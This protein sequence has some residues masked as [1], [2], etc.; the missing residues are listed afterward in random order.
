VLDWEHFPAVKRAHVVPR[1]Y[2]QAFAVDGQV[3]VHVDGNERCVLMPISEAGTRSRYYRRVRR[4]G[5]SIDDVE[6]SLSVV[7]DKAARPLAELI[8]GDLV[9]VERKR[10]LTQFIALQMLRGPAFFERREEILKP[11]LDNLE[12][13]DFKSAALAT[14]GGNVEAARRQVVKAYLDPTQRFVTMLATA[15]KVAN[16]LAHMRWNVLRFESSLLA[17][18]D[19]PVVVWP[20]TLDRT[21]PFPKQGF[22]PLSAFEIRLPLAPDV[23]L[24]MNWV[25][26]SDQVDVALRPR[27][28]A[29][30]NAFTIAQADRQWMHQPRSP[31]DVPTGPFLPL[32]RLV[33]PDYDQSVM[34]SSARRGRAAEFLN[35]VRRRRFVDDIEIIIDVAP[36]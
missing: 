28:A 11:L 13:K 10:A 4:G 17:Y 8:A 14:V 21:R 23:A 7:E 20:E 3:A 31:P 2:Q 32:S 33:D 9:T 16:V 15:V 1:V 26:R 29:E 24:L 5:E 12:A 6:A 30:L 35:R 34:S 22:G 36:P 18:S 25:D 27:A 19:H